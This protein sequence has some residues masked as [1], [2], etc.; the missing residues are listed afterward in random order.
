MVKVFQQFCAYRLNIH[1][2]VADYIKGIFFEG[3]N[4][5]IGYLLI[6][7]GYALCI[8]LPRNDLFQLLIVFR[9]I[10]LHK[11]FYRFAGL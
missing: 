10:G 2:P 3:Y 11:Q 9:T 8:Y 7:V 6:C 1:L 4:G 5:G